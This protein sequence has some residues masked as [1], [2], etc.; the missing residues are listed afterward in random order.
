MTIITTTLTTTTMTETPAKCPHVTIEE[1]TDPNGKDAPAPAP[2]TMAHNIIIATVESHPALIQ[3]LCTTIFNKFS[4]LKNKE[5]QQLNTLSRL[6]EDTFLP[7]SARLAFEMHASNKVMETEEFK[8]LAASMAE[9][10]LEC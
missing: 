3:R 2:S 1:E 8:T 9:L 7:R 6:T 5:R 10:M 4:A